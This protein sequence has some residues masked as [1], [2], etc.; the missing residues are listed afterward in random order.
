MKTLEVSDVR[1]VLKHEK[2]R[3]RACREKDFEDNRARSSAATEDA[4]S[5]VLMI[6]EL[7]DGS[8]GAASANEALDL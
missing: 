1:R 6:E 4:L 8:A 5:R 7:L 3:L 2:K